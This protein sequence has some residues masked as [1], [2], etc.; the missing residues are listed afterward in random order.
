[1]LL[2]RESHQQ[3]TNGHGFT[4][5]RNVTTTSCWKANTKSN[6]SLLN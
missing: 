4:L 6:N 2:T 1:M 5:Q 3:K